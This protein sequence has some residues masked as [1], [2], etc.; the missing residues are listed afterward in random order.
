MTL[1]AF[2]ALKRCLRKKVFVSSLNIRVILSHLLTSV[3]ENHISAYEI[4]EYKAILLSLTNY[5]DSLAELNNMLSGQV[6]VRV[7][8]KWK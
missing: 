6:S 4:L 8:A 7:I 5:S 2:A 1:K 3:T